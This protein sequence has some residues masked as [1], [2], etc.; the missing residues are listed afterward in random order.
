MRPT[1]AYARRHGCCSAKGAASIRS[2][3]SGSSR[4]P[5]IGKGLYPVHRFR[6]RCASAAQAR[7]GE[8]SQG[9]GGCAGP[10]V[11]VA[12]RGK[13]MTLL[14]SS[15]A[16]LP[17]RILAAIQQSSLDVTQVDNRG[18]QELQARRRTSR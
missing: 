3:G 7:I 8:D 2:R 17:S 12:A 9:A 16:E 11:Y 6:L 14:V 4:Q 5:R 13:S 15:I 18:S 1:G 10:K